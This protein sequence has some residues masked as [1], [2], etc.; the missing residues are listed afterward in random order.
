MNGFR[1]EI[2]QHVY[3][4]ELFV[5]MVMIGGASEMRVDYRISVYCMKMGKQVD[6]GEI[7]AEQKQKEYCGICP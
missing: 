1:H 6:I 3:Y 5:I 4:R 2:R 7:P